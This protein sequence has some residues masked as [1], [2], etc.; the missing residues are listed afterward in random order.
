MTKIYDITI[1][2]K[3]N[4]PAFP[5]DESFFDCKDILKVE[6]GDLYSI[7]RLTIL[8]HTGTHLDA[9]SHFIQGAKNLSDFSLDKFVGIADV[10]EIND[11]EKI[12]F[13]ELKKLPIEK[14]TIVLFKTKNSKLWAQN[15]KF[16]EKYI[17]I[18]P[19]AALYL[20]E[21]DI[22]MVGIDYLSA[23]KYDEIGTADT[24]HILL[25]ND[26]PILEGIDLSEVPA[27]RY[28]LTCLPLKLQ[29]TD[30]APVRAI[31]EEI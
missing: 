16:Y 5:G 2:M 22:K 27:G 25:G 13:D 3:D 18:T 31:L 17:Y 12:D 8:T 30:G 14:N 19:E 24:H 21:K 4:M 9:P 26:I 23:D 11:D 29:N 6:E 15:F 1:P 7:K 28:K 20:V 10:F